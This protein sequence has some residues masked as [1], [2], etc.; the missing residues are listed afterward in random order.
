M[1][2]IDSR[3]METDVFDVCFVGPEEEE[4]FCCFCCC[5]SLTSV[6]SLTSARMR[7]V[8]SSWRRDFHSRCSRVTCRRCH[9]YAA[10]SAVA[11]ESSNA[12][13]G[14]TAAAALLSILMVGVNLMFCEKSKNEGGAE[15]DGVDSRRTRTD[16]CRL[17]VGFAPALSLESSLARLYV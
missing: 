12:V 13:T 6:R 8:R 17:S 1:T 11:V 5:C 3:C 9:Q 2:P 4:D 7:P 14:T 16:T 10:D 15:T